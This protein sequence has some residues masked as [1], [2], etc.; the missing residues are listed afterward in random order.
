MFFTMFWKEIK[1][2]I[3]VYTGKA[4][5]CYSCF[6][7]KMRKSHNKNDR[8]SFT[9]FITTTTDCNPGKQNSLRMNTVL[10]KMT[11]NWKLLL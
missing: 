6:W 9:S 2:K 10:Q 8:L 1:L 4:R 11:C 7:A 3:L 5:L